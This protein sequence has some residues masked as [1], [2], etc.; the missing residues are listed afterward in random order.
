MKRLLSVLLISTFFIVLVAGILVV[1]IGR[2]RV[3]VLHS[4][5][6]DYIW[7]EEVNVGLQRIFEDQPNLEVKYHEMGTKKH[8]DEDYLRRAGVAARDNIDRFEPDVLIAVDDYAQKLV[9][10]EYVNHPEMDIVFAGVNGEIE[11]YG[12]EGANNVTGILERKPVRALRQVLMMLHTDLGERTDI[13]PPRVLFLSDSS[14][15]A[16][17]DAGYLQASDWGKVIYYGHWAVSDYQ[18]WREAVEELE[19]EVDYI[20]VGAYRKLPRDGEAK[21]G[22]EGEAFVPADEIMTWTE[23]H[24][25]VAVIGLNV[26]NSRDGAMFSVGVSPFEQGETAAEMAMK[27][28][29][30]GK[31][32]A[33]IPVVT[34]RQY[35]IA[36]RES[37]LK[38]RQFKVPDVFEAFARATDNYFE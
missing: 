18:E 28:I 34:S 37:A 13:R 29:R 24:S 26:F 38:R 11:P 35:V 2:P 15:S 17:Q 6:S 33:D 30:E 16:E 7:T 9:A 32:P 10:K 27:I 4:Y 20:L 21:A 14:H 8:N 3:M 1:N 12:Y 23:A 22:E 25:E 19:G 36:M 31:R 5:D